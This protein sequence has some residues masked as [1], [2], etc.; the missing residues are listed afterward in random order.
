MTLSIKG[1][2]VKFSISDTY[3]RCH[4]TR[5]NNIHHTAFSVITLIIIKDKM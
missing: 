4:Y 5:H 3:Y 2:Y 1:L